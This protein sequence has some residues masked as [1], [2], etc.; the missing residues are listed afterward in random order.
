M[1]ETSSLTKFLEQHGTA[2]TFGGVILIVIGVLFLL[3]YILDAK[4]K[5]KLGIAQQFSAGPAALVISLGIVL[6]II[7]PGMSFMLSM[8]K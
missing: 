1:S 5:D 4:R 3:A 7:Q 2:I 6:L 8:M